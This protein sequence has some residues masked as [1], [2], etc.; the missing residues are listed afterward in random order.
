M[1]T[2]IKLLAHT[3]AIIVSMLACLHPSQASQNVPIPDRPTNSDYIKEGDWAWSAL[4]KLKMLPPG[5]HH[6]V[7]HPYLTF[8]EGAVEVDRFDR[9]AELKAIQNHI[10]APTVAPEDRAL[11]NRLFTAFEPELRAIGYFDR[12]PLDSPHF[13]DVPKH[14]WAYQAV[15]DLKQKG[16]LLGYPSGRFNSE[17]K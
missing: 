16:I 11:L 5:P 4:V 6:F 15:T 14:H 7:S 9:I 1:S 12:R 13:P 8:Y 2:R 3:L 17:T 10:Q